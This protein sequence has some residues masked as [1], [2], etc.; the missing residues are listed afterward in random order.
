MPFSPSR[1]LSWLL[2]E[3]A[4]CEG[5]GTKPPNFDFVVTII[6]AGWPSRIPC[7]PAIMYDYVTYLGW[8]LSS[9]QWL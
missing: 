7:Q 5:A 6:A 1:L 9:H 4:E 2:N 8:Q 3:V